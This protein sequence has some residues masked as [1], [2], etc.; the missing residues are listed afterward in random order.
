M[1]FLPPVVTGPII[2]LIGL[3]LAP[4]AVSNA[5]S[6]WWLALVS[7]AIIIVANIWGQRHD[8][9]HSHPAGCGRRLCGRPC[10]P[11]M[12]DCLTALPASSLLTGENAVLGLQPFLKN[13]SGSRGQV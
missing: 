12:V 6:C 2:I 1:H 10:A 9:D 13:F 11:A 7:M 4:S 5:S 8:Q 3:N